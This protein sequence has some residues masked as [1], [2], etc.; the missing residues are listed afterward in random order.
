MSAVLLI[1]LE[2][3][4]LVLIARSVFSWIRPNPYGPLGQINQVLVTITEPV[5]GPVR[6]L[7]PRTGPFDFSLLIVLILI[8][9][10]LVP[11]A[12]RL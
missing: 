7:L 5:V 1:L 6:R 9:V 8:N 10:V 2:V 4:S 11:I 3:F 12:S